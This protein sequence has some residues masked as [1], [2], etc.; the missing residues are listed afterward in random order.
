MKLED[1]KIYKKAHKLAVEI[2]KLSLQLPKFEMHEE[3]SQI[4]RSSKS[5][6]AQIVEGYSLRNYKNEYIHYLY[7]SYASNRETKEHLDLLYETNSFNDGSQYKE[8]CLEIDDLSR[9][10]YA[11]I[12]S[13]E[14]KHIIRKA[15][16]QSA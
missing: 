8:L 7:R 15:N 9:M 12:N 14:S 11:F 16:N 2:H 4:R 13:V 3:G 5:T 1:L 10:I 6:S